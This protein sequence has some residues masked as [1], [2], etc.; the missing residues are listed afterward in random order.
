MLASVG[1]SSVK[2]AC[3]LMTAALAGGEQRA[4]SDHFERLA[5]HDTR[6]SALRSP[7]VWAGALETRGDGGNRDLE[8]EPKVSADS[9]SPSRAG[10]LH[11]VKNASIYDSSGGRRSRSSAAS[12]AWRASPPS[13]TGTATA[14][15]PLP[16]LSASN[17]SNRCGWTALLLLLLL[18]GAAST[19]LST[20][21]P[22]AW[23]GSTTNVPCGH[24]CAPNAQATQR[25]Y[26]TAVT[27]CAALA[28]RCLGV[29]SR[30]TASC[31]SCFACD[32]GV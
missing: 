3:P 1:E 6:A 17:S 26:C 15:W 13:D 29:A 27:A 22:V 2:A 23:N 19:R 25:L 12:T 14:S 31:G 10:T 21:P 18:L 8:R 20:A 5:A 4:T 16:A 32:G 7:A 24:V 9:M 11:G 28:R 30:S